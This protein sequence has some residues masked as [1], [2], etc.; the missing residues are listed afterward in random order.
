MQVAE[1]V[2]L[3]IMITF[4][5]HWYIQLAHILGTPRFSNEWDFLRTPLFPVLLKLF[6]WI[7]GECAQSVLI[8]QA[9]LGF[10]GIWL[11]RCTLERLG[12]RVESCV[13]LILLSGFPVMV[14]YEHAVLTEIGSFFFLAL[15]LFVL[16]VLPRRAWLGA[17]VIGLVIAAGFY[18][19]SSFLYL[20][21]L[22]A[23]LYLLR[24]LR[25]ESPVGSLKC[26]L[27]GKTWARI[28]GQSALVL[29]LPIV[30]AWP[31]QR[32]PKVEIR[33][34]SVLDYGVI[35]Q[36]VIPP[37]DPIW[38][39]AAGVYRDVVDRS[40]RNGRLP[41]D[42]LQN[43]SEYRVMAAV[44]TGS[45]TD[46][47][48]FRHAIG[49]F[50][51]RYLAAIARNILFDAGFSGSTDS[52]IFEARVLAEQESNI[53]A[54]PPGFP[55]LDQAFA[56]RTGRSAVAR[57]LRT[58]NPAYEVLV[59]LGFPAACLLL[60]AGLR[61]MDPVML[62]LGSLPLAFIL[63][64]T[65]TLSSQDRMAV[66][67]YPLLLFC[68]VTLPTFVG[69][70]LGRY[71]SISAEPRYWK[72]DH[73]AL[74]LLVVVIAGLSLCH[75]LYLVISRAI[76]TSDEAHYMSGV[77][78]IAQGLRSGSPVRLFREYTSALGFKP[79]LIC[80]PAAM[81]SLIATDVV[82]SARLSLVLIFIGVAISS[83]LLFRILFRPA[84]A[85]FAT[86]LVATAPVVTGLSHSFYTE[87]LLL[88]IC[89]VYLQALV[90][91]PFQRWRSQIL[92]GV[93]LGLGLLAKSLVIPLLLPG[94]LYR[95][96]WAWRKDSGATVS[97]LSLG[98]QAMRLL[99][100]GIV[101]VAVA[102]SWYAFHSN[103]RH[104]AEWARAGATCVDC[105]YPA[106]P[107][108]LADL[109]DVATLPVAIM[110]M[111]GLFPAIAW[112]RKLPKDSVHRLLSTILLT[113]GIVICLLSLF[114]TNKSIRYLAVLL[115]ASS[116]LAVFGATTFCRTERTR[117]WSIAA[118]SA[119]SIAMVV[120]NSF[121]ILPLPSIRV[122]DLRILDSSFPLNTPDWFDDNHPADKR[123][124]QIAKAFERLEADA[125][126]HFPPG[127]P[128]TVGLLVHGILINHDYL[129]LLATERSSALRFMPY[130]LTAVRGPGAPE[131][132]LSCKGCGKVYPGRHYADISPELEKSMASG[133]GEY[134]M[135]FSIPAPTSCRLEGFRRKAHISAEA[136]VNGLKLLSEPATG[137]IDS[138]N[139]RVWPS[140]EPIQVESQFP[141]RVSGWAA[142]PATRQPAAAVYVRIRNQVFKAEYGIPRDDVAS[143]LRNPALKRSG[144]SAEIPL[145]LLTKGNATLR[146][147]VVSSTETGYYVGPGQEISMH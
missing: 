116:F 94:T 121:R 31:W 63:M 46:R 64:Q 113:T 141:L 71:V 54:P 126:M 50:P 73:V 144:F 51:G 109:S 85:A 91:L 118:L 37:D 124:F 15:L 103:F 87:L 106:A 76:P 119:F 146:I 96:Y 32:N 122:G 72:S 110:A 78:G 83:Y 90:R 67:A 111:V 89:V 98:V 16:V 47:A 61:L 53:S 36:A 128:L 102:A 59:L 56:L 28:G 70:P 17:I 14:T 55:S 115:P 80:V 131:Y 40:L 69:A 45:R 125:K 41:L 25:R 92:L 77:W 49:V 62:T 145:K 8:L 86:L 95:A 43:G 52:T 2:S 120:H 137:F 68:I 100:L 127:L 136:S 104:V 135:I 29:F 34:N 1:L 44:G 140:S 75:I 79:P 132:L 147:L 24:L 101:A 107:A 81:I 27:S 82:V 6:F 84:L 26:G 143:A 105:D 4:D 114:T 139:S 99:V 60:C 123:D 108:F 142:D 22:A 7:F 42:G 9:L 3:P 133:A 23:F 57:L 93:V 35:R 20:S 12:R 66:P 10:S 19:R 38:G 65:L 39:T 129:T 48:M 74:R 13:L 18:H 134:E 30:L 130:Y 88:L 112:I 11:L 5:G 117:L 21:P 33:T 138:I 58:A 97:V